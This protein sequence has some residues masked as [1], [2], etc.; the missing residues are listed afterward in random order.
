[1][2]DIRSSQKRT[3]EI[4]RECPQCSVLNENEAASIFSRDSWKIKTC[5]QCSFYYLENVIPYSELIKNYAWTETSKME[6]E[7]R[8]RR[9]PFLKKLSNN[10]SWFKT[11]ILKRDKGSKIISN[12]LISGKLLDVGCGTGVVLKKLPEGIIPFGIE[13]ESKTAILTNEYAI[14]K[15]GR[16]WHNDAVSGLNEIDEGFFDC[17]LMQSYL[18]HEINPKEV[19]NG[20]FHAIKK[21]GFIIIKVPN[22]SCWNRYLRKENW[23]G[24]RFP[25]HVN[26]FTP[27]T[28]KIM[29][30]NAGF[31]IHRFGLADRSPLSDNMWMILV[32]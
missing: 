2:S 8:L 23:C 22:F 1:V 18:E 32:K 10:F 28:L 21:N 3:N 6:N 16:V 29:A 4:I 12:L 13:I 27:S 9:S 25:D 19:L 20:A 7:F 5:K 14:K 31:K 26:Y 17:I 24:F 11:N 30:L 15:G